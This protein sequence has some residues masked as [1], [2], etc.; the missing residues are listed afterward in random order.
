MFI[1]LDIVLRFQL[2]NLMYYAE[3]C[4]KFAVPISTSLLPGSTAPSEK[5]L[6]RWRAIGNTVPNLTSP[7]FELSIS[8]SRDESVIAS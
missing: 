2:I 7:R 6:Q 4:S 1:K 3:A 8:R 5:M